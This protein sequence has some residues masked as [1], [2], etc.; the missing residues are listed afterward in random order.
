M[1]AVQLTIMLDPEGVA[2][3]FFGEG[4]TTVMFIVLKLRIKYLHLFPKRF[5]DIFSLDWKFLG[6][7]ASLNKYMK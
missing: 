4:A 3:T 2:V 1:F 5:I 7:Q 6:S